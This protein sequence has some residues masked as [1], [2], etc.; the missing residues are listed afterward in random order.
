VGNMFQILVWFFKFL[1]ELFFDRK[2]EADF[3]SEHFKPKRWI[4]FIVTVLTFTVSVF[5]G[6]RLVTLAQDYADLQKKNN[7]CGSKS[8]EV[9]P[10]KP[11]TTTFNK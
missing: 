7:N 6:T 11:P 3:T 9:K 1:R 4:A 8:I 10:P 2:E 5:M